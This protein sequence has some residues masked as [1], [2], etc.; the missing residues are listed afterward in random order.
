MLQP[1]TR[2]LSQWGRG[3]RDREFLKLTIT[4]EFFI[5]N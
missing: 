5:K 4:D 1:F 3:L 2:Q